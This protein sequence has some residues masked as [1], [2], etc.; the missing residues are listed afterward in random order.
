MKKVKEERHM[1]KVRVKLSQTK[2]LLTMKSIGA[3]VWPNY[4]KKIFKERLK[5]KDNTSGW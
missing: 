4:P 2:K 5:W 1:R 3:G